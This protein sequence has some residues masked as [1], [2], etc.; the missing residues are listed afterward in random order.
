MKVRAENCHRINGQKY[1]SV[2][3]EVQEMNHVKDTRKTFQSSGREQEEKM[4]GF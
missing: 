3:Y 4:I 1:G 2:K